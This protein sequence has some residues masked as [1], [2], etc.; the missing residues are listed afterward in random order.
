[1]CVVAFGTLVRRARARLQLLRASIPVARRRVAASRRRGDARVR[2]SA[3]GKGIREL[4]RR[5]GIAALIALDWAAGSLVAALGIILGDAIVRR[6]PIRNAISNAGHFLTAGSIAGYCYY[7]LM[8]GRARTRRLRRRQCVAT[9]HYDRAVPHHGERHVLSAAQ[10]LAGNRVG[11]REAHRTMG[12]APS[13]CSRRYSRS[14][15]PARV[16]PVR[17]AHNGRGRAGD[18]AGHVLT[19]WL[20][21]QAAVGESLLLVQRLTTRSARAR[22]STRAHDIQRLTRSLVPWEQMGIASYDAERNDFVVLSTRRPT[23]RWAPALPPGGD[24][25]QRAA[26]RTCDHGSRTS[27]RAAPDR[28]VRAL[29]DRASAQVR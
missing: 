11:G 8:S 16:Q 18:D 27:D 21:R 29:E 22:S 4:R 3:S 9:R 28:R 17:A 10:A 12:R 13:P 15:A 2:H 5:P 1:M 26:R 19:H 6:L 20:V 14:A 23:C 24:G 7:G 25:E